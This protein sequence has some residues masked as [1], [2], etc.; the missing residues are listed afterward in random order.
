LAVSD[1]FIGYLWVAQQLESGSV[2]GVAYDGLWKRATPPQRPKKLTIAD[3]F[4]RTLIVP[5]QDMVIEYGVELAKTAL[6]MASDPYI[7]KN[8]VWQGC[9]DC[10]FEQLCR[11]QSSG[12]D[13]DYIISNQY[14]TRTED[15]AS[16]IVQQVDTHPMMV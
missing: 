8:R 4:C 6:E 7:Y 3:L 2:L 15:D 1:Q 14:T 5:P 13:I 16:D 10:S 12:D 11:S 9:W